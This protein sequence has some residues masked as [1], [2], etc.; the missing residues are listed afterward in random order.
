MSIQTIL[1]VGC[2]VGSLVLGEYDGDTVVTDGE[3][4]GRF[5]GMVVGFL[6]SGDTIGAGIG[7]ADGLAVRV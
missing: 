2:G 3:P 6:V 1:P 4:V 5:V 7:L